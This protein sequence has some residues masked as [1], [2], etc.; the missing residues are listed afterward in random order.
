MS[1]Q[2]VPAPRSRSL[3]ISEIC[4]HLPPASIRYLATGLAPTDGDIAV[5]EVLE[6]GRHD[7]LDLA[8]GRSVPLSPGD[9]IVVALG[10]HYAPLDFTG[11]CPDAL[12]DCALLSAA[13][14][15]GV[16][17]EAFAGRGPTRLRLLGLAADVDGDTLN[18]R[19][20][21]PTTA[22][23]ETGEALRIAVVSCARGSHASAVTAAMVRGFS[24]SG[25]AVGVA[26]PTG[27][28]DAAERWRF[29]DNGALAAVDLV[30]AGRLCSAELGADELMTVSHSLIGTL[31]AAGADTMLMRIAGG[32]ARRDTRTLLMA[33]ALR[34]LLRGVV[35][36]AADALSAIEGARRLHAVGLPVLAVSGAICRSPLAMAEARSGLQ[37]PV[38]DARALAMPDRL[39]ALL[40]PG[41]GPSL[42]HDPRALA[43]AA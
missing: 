25:R 33:P 13:G 6:C 16:V 42:I 17:T 20:L 19:R 10:R 41:A 37:C 8:Q 12:G 3:K 40:E 18:L 28:V 30:D 38:L 35:L 4:R 2:L 23:A 31:H 21:L 26:K 9:L 32:L 24:R 1:I 7:Q 5:A 22:N 11:A 27:V 43:I 36:A 39:Q 14:A 34:P 15:A 29:L